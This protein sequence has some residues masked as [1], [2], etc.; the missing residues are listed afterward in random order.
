MCLRYP[1]VGEGYVFELPAGG[2]RVCVLSYLLVGDGYVFA[3]GQLSQ[4]AHV[5][6][7]V[8]LAADQKDPSAGAEVQ[9]LCLPL[10]DGTR[11]AY[12]QAL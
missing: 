11:Q 5:G 3:V 4:C 12:Y 9:D 8:R 2:R 6:A 7:Q 10:R 1:L